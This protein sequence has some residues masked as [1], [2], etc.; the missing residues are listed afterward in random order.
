MDAS[1][2]RTGPLKVTFQPM[3]C[4]TYPVKWCYDNGKIFIPQ[5]G[6]G[7]STKS[8]TS[9]VRDRR[10]EVIHRVQNENTNDIDACI[11]QLE[12]GS[13]WFCCLGQ[14][15]WDIT[16]RCGDP[17]YPSS[18]NLNVNHNSHKMMGLQLKANEFYNWKF[19][20]SLDTPTILI[21]TTVTP[22]EEKRNWT[23]M[24]SFTAER[25]SEANRL[26]QL[27]QQ[28]ATL[29]KN[30]L[31]TST[32]VKEAPKGTGLV[33]RDW[34]QAVQQ[35]EKQAKWRSRVL[36]LKYGWQRAG[37]KARNVAIANNL[38]K[39]GGSS[40][41]GG[42]RISNTEPTAPV[43]DEAKVKLLIGMGIARNHAIIALTRKYNSM[44]H[45][46]EWYFIN[47][48]TLPPADN[49]NYNNEVKEEENNKRGGG[50]KSANG[51]GLASQNVGRRKALKQSFTIVVDRAKSISGERYSPTQ[52][53]E[54]VKH[55]ADNSSLIQVLPARLLKPGTMMI[56][57]HSKEAT[58][59]AEQ[60]KKLD[61]GSPALLFNVTRTANVYVAVDRRLAEKEILPSWLLN[62]DFQP[63][64]DDVVIVSHS[65]I[66][67]FVLFVKTIPSASEV[68]LGPSGTLS[69][70]GYLPYFVFIQEV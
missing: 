49:S 24:V 15:K 60:R 23:S 68:S 20:T 32:S 7:W 2:K 52:A 69:H 47:M 30:S 44:D 53:M 34:V 3:S 11:A 14:G 65:E 28:G 64:S 37:K 57:T 35:E 66:D 25:T 18:V 58:Q 9:H 67:Y 17:S 5:R 12:P 48:N 59:T 22:G 31:R 26:R 46:V 45:A 38:H 8:A 56:Q 33:Q 54:G 29:F 13:S 21:E 39:L 40:S 62:D 1:T 50:Q 16:I 10:K 51:T 4:D 27:S 63:I 42:S 70:G 6:Y 43:V 61:T 19:T 41:S 36:R 55:H